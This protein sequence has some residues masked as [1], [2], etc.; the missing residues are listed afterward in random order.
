MIWV[1]GY[2]V[3]NL[4]VIVVGAPLLLGARVSRVSV[5][6]VLVACLAGAFVVAAIATR[7][8]LD[9]RR[10]ARLRRRES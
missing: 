8:W 10:I 1:L 9:D 2:V 4:F 5:L 6:Y 7:D 3:L